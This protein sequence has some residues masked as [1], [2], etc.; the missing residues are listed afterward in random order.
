MSAVA[1]WGR[2][3]LVFDRI[4]HSL[5]ETLNYARLT[6]GFDYLVESGNDPRNYSLTTLS[7][8]QE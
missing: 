8:G 5:G 3:Y 1:P 4:S 2:L 7:I 6:T